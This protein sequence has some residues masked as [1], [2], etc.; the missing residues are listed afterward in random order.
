MGRHAD[1]TPSAL[2]GATS[3]EHAE[4]RDPAALALE[5]DVDIMRPI[6]TVAATA[7]RVCSRRTR[8]LRSHLNE[9]WAR[10]PAPSLDPPPGSTSS[11]RLLMTRPL[12]RCELT[13]QRNCPPGRVASGV[14]RSRNHTLGPLGPGSRD[15]CLCPL[16]R[17]SSSQPEPRRPSRVVGQIRCLGGALQAVRSRA[18][19][20]PIE[21]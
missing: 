17:E 13:D 18:D 15:L 6:A 21:G 3:L 19:R 5:V 9:P 10:N 1:A 4:A 12:G 16:S 20:A 7:A 2:T 11:R 14:Q 8:R